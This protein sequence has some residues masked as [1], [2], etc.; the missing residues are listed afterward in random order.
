MPIESEFG[1][2][3]R[4][5]TTDHFIERHLNLF[6][7][8]ITPEEKK[9][10]IR[11]MAQSLV[12]IATLGNEKA[13]RGETDNIVWYPSEV[14]GFAAN[15]HLANSF[16]MYH[17]RLVCK[18]IDRLRKTLE[19]CKEICTMGF[20]YDTPY[21]LNEEEMSEINLGERDGTYQLFDA[22]AMRA[23]QEALGKHLRGLTLR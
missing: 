13:S 14:W 1:D 9:K 15:F 10:V 23:F 2:G 4:V 18:K 3:V 8:A 19:H 6:D 7:E 17:G 21:E 11:R 16:A 12:D 22:E 20:S 5:H